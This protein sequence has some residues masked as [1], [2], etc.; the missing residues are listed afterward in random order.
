MKKLQ[1]MDAASRLA[2]DPFYASYLSLRSI[3]VDVF[4]SD[5]P[6]KDPLP[7]TSIG[8]DKLLLELGVSRGE[9][10]Q[11]EGLAALGD[12]VEAQLSARAIVRLA[13]DP[14]P[15]VG[16]MQ[17]RTAKWL[18]R[19]F[20]LGLRFSGKNMSPL[21][22]WLAGCHSVALNMSNNDLPVQLHFALFRGS[23][24]Y[25]L[26]PPE[27][28]SALQDATP[29]RSG[30]EWRRNQS[31]DAYWP[32]PRAT[33]HRTTIEILSLHHLP[34]VRLGTTRARRH[35]CAAG[36]VHG[37]RPRDSLQTSKIA[38][39]QALLVDHDLRA[40]RVP[41]YVPHHPS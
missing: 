24:G 6:P 22:G 26:K 3:P 15:E 25:V 11:I 13:A 2:T 39:W 29:S 14:A 12:Q 40:N 33:L 18:T 9:R 28:R 41:Y 8:E 5:E 31:A 21:P 35:S 34:A 17:R 32:P 16:V 23:G 4:L 37:G 27:M 1:K 19:P 38:P 10:D 20:P 36:H 7:I 30:D